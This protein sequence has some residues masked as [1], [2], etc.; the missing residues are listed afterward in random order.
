MN[1]HLL[2]A[3]NAGWMVC[4]QETLSHCIPVPQLTTVTNHSG[5]LCTTEGVNKCLQV[6]G[7]CIDL[8]MGMNTKIF[9]SLEN[10]DQI[11]VKG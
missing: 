9:Y 7:V 6:V 4:G 1:Q 3:H 2:L 8:P 5:Q 10:W 11:L